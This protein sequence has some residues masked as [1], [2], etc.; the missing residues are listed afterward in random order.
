MTSTELPVSM[1]CWPGS[2]AAAGVQS[3]P[4]GELLLAVFLD[5][6]NLVLTVPPFPQG[7]PVMAVFLRQ[8]ARAAGRMAAELDPTTPPR[9]TGGAHRALPDGPDETGALR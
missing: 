9:R 2:R 6:V 3:T 8:L 5:P 7:A 4:G 1:W